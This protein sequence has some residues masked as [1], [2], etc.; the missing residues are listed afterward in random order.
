MLTTKSTLK[1]S[2]AA[3]RL[4]ELCIRDVEAYNASFGKPSKEY[5]CPICRNK[6]YIREVDYDPKFGYYA[7]IVKRC[8]CWEKREK[9]R[10]KADLEAVNALYSLDSF[11]AAE[12]WQQKMLTA[13]RNYLFH[14]DKRFFF[15]GGAV[16]SGKSHICFGILRKISG[17]VKVM[18]WS[19][20]I[21][22]LKKFADEDYPRLINS[23]VYPDVLY[24]EDFFRRTTRDGITDSDKNIAFDIVN[25]RY[26]QKK[27]TIF[28]SEYTLDEIIRTDNAIGSRIY[29]MAGDDF[30]ISIGREKGRDYRLK[31]KDKGFD[32]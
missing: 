5:D 12:S 28:S 27:R 14:G 29:E 10:E 11:V 1:S 31:Q 2:D 19:S 9:L 20:D 22:R 25:S 8:A 16:G 6:K 4:E 26:L 13:A 3:K 32:L 30:R 17:K 23:F 15:A 24:I 18:Y 7:P 21:M